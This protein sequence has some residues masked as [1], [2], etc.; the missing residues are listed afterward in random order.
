MTNFTHQV[1]RALQLESAGKRDA[2]NKLYCIVIRPG[3]L[4]TRQYFVDYL[5][6]SLDPGH[7]GLAK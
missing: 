7:P 4:G 1:S 3:S 6:K 5:C 2:L